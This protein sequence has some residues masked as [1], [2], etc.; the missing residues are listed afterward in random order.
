MLRFPRST[1]TPA[2]G[3]VV[4]SMPRVSPNLIFLSIRQE[5]RA[6]LQEASPGGRLA[7]FVK[8]LLKFVLAAAFHFTGLTGPLLRW[9]LRSGRACLILG[10]H[11]TNEASPG[12]F[13]RGHSIVNVRDQLRYLKRHLRPVTLEEIAGAVARGDS[14][15]E[16]SFAVT[17]DDGL[18]SNVTHALPMLRDLDIPATFFIPSGLIGSSRDL[19]VASLR[20]IV[21]AWPGSIIP[22]EDGW[23]PALPV[24]GEASRHAAFHR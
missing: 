7:A 9:A 19:W 11:G 3:H 10:F 4:R 8:Q 2:G 18:A 12:Y 15:P 5:F 13:S 17:F 16:A 14:P 20:E 21:R 6:S 22:E 1:T 23:W 24:D